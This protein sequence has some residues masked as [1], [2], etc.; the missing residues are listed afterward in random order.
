MFELLVF[1][2]VIFFGDGFMRVIFGCGFF[3]GDEMDDFG[4]EVKG[5][6][7][8]RYRKEYCVIYK[9]FF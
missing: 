6:V 8:F 9:Y 1:V 7:G 2:C 5:D 4:G 3:F